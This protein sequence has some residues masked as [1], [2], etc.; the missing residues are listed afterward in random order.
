M[1]DFTA[2]RNRPSL[3]SFPWLR[4]LSKVSKS[5]VLVALA[6]FALTTVTGCSHYKL[7]EVDAPMNPFGDAHNGLAKVC[8]L[9]T[10][11][12]A[13]AVTFVAWDNGTLV[14]ATRGPTHFCYWSEPGE[15]D[16]FVDANGTSHT[17]YRAE[18]GH[19]Y[20]LHEKVR[21]FGAPLAE[22]EW[23]D[24][25]HAEKLFP[26]SSYAA[27]VGVPTTETLANG[28][29]VARVRAQASARSSNR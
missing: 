3:P 1:L 14:G 25:A 9:K 2:R 24:A 19:S 22:L 23:V 8:I 15:H 26:S 20:F 4:R 18:A 11:N 21:F 13:L 27:L 28:V 16:I 5:G 6:A 17:H 12:V 7:R 29:P 10:T